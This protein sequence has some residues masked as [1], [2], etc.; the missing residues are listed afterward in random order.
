MNIPYQILEDIT[1]KFSGDLLIGRGGYGDV[2]KGVLDNGEL[3]AVK[4]LHPVL[5]LDDTLFNREVGN[6]L[7]VQHKNIVQLLGYCH[8][9]RSEFVEHNGQNVWCKHI[10]A[11]ICFEYFQGGSLDKHLHD[12]SFAPNWTTCYNIIKGI[13]EGVNFL[14]GC[15]PPIFHLDLKPAN[16][17]LDN[18]MLPKVADFGLSRLFSGSHTHVTKKM[19]GTEKYMPPE[20]INQHIISPK[21]DVFSLGVVIIEIMKGPM[22]YSQFQEM[23]DVTQFISEVLADWRNVINGTSKYPLEEIYQVKACIDIAVRCVEP[24]RNNRP[25]IAG[26]LDSLPK[27]EAHR[28]K[29]QL[30]D[31]H[32]CPTIGNSMAKKLKTMADKVDNMTKRQQHSNFMLNESFNFNMQQVPDTRATSSTV[33]ETFIIG[34]TKEK[35]KIL[36]M[37]SGSSNKEMAILPIYGIGGIGKTT[38]AQLVFNDTQFQGYSRVWVYVSQQFSLYKI[39]NSIIS[40]LSNNKISHIAEKQMLHN[41]LTGLLSSKRILI[42]LDDLW[43]EDPSVLDDLKAILR[44]GIR[45]KVTVIVT[46]RD[47]AIA[48]NICS[49]IVP[50]KLDNL[51]NEMCWTIIKQKSKFKNR[52]D[53]KQLEHIGMEIAMKCAGIALAAQSMGYTL[54]FKSYDIWDSVRNSDI[55]NSSVSEDPLFRSHEVLASL[56]LSYSHMHECLQ[57]CFSYCAVFPKGRNIA[58]YDLIHQ[59]IALELTKP[60]GTFDSMQLCEQYVTQLL[61][62]SFLQCSMAPSGDGQHDKDVTLFTMH[63]LVHDLA[64]AMLA[65]KVNKKG[66]PVGR[67]CHFALLTDCSKPISLS[68]SYSENTWLGFLRRL[69]QKKYSDENIKALHFLDCGNK[70]LCGPAFSPAKGLLVLDLSECFIRKLPDSVGEMKQLRYLCAPRIQDQIVPNC[71]A[72]LTRLNYL[73]LRGS[74]NISALPESIGDIEGL[75][76]LD[77]SGC[78]S[79]S[80]LPISFAELRN[81]V[82]LD[83]SH[84]HVSISEALGGLTKLQYLN[85]SVEVGRAAKHI[86]VLPQVIRTLTKLRYLNLSKCL[87]VMAPSKVE[88]HNLLDSVSTLSNLEHLDLSHNYKL[89]SIPESIGNL[90]KLHTLDLSEC[91]LRRLP[92]SIAEMTSLKVLTA[93]NLDKSPAPRLHFASLPNF[94]VCAFPSECSSNLFLLQPT[95]PSTLKISGLENVMSTEEAEGIKLMDKLKM[96]DLTL[97][98]TVDSEKRCLDDKDVL[99]KLVPPNTIKTLYIGGYSSLGF[100]SWLMGIGLYLPNLCSIDLWYFPKCNNLPPLGQLPNLELLRLYRMDS[101]EEWNTTYS[102]G[103]GG[104][105]DLM[106]PKLKTVYVRYCAKLSIKPCLPR[107]VST[108]FIE[109]SDNVVTLGDCVPQ[110]SAS[111]SSALTNLDIKKC[112]VPLHQW[113]LLKHISN[114]HTLTIGECSDLTSCSPE[115]IQCLATLKSLSLRKSSYRG[116]DLAEPPT[117]LVQ[118]TSLQRLCITLP[119]LEKLNDNTRKLTRLES[120][121]LMECGSMSSLPQWLGE[122]A[123]LKELIISECEG[124]KSLPD[125]IQQLT[126][127]EHLRIYGGCPTLVKW[128]ESEENKMKLTHIKGKLFW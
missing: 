20:S 114:L 4:L 44:L 126:K 86:K 123:S 2:Y 122:L 7:R 128:C 66:D 118:L 110:T 99:G 57:S 30:A 38:L 60:S 77:L 5:A 100:P 76:H 93:R 108:L 71:I 3:I 127:L 56:R 104:A 50:Y 29:R 119:K 10:Y 101:L 96:E 31:V 64:R 117:W 35:Q 22:G 97:K 78:E 46:T 72:K 1:N 120:L 113:S 124:I 9:I 6:L 70:E 52:H 59:W 82:H 91:N 19:I 53:K 40:Q 12:Q 32:P 111:Y 84:C 112:M 27:T 73:N 103:E 51:T 58:K 25:T 61:G 106:F 65:D 45:S 98:W 49:N 43:K 121:S 21:N 85:L 102:G 55:W 67:S 47:E 24:E 75:M 80:E 63:D 23:G 18:S 48:R 95:N 13:C 74:L 26:I 109:G 79:I 87:Y 37:L 68:M 8:E 16:I 42:V 107:A 81:L 90:T 14:H 83:L 94:S 15:E 105:N 62:M 89:N 39:G 17:L 69:F 125:S 88:I 11:V 28:T 54:R 36:S 34:R 115:M 33:K 41:R 92:S 116:V